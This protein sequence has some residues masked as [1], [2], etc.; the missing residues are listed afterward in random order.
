VGDLHED[1]VG[2]RPQDDAVDRAVEQRGEEVLVGITAPEK[3][4]AQIGT[5]LIGRSRLPAGEEMLPD[6]SHRTQASASKA[7]VAST[8]ASGSISVAINRRALLW[9]VDHSGSWPSHG[10][11]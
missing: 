8:A 2:E 11:P 3:R 6:T 7:A 5:R 1:V 10:T 4:S 9:K